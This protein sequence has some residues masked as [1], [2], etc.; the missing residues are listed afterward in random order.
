MRKGLENRVVQRATALAA[1]AGTLVLSACGRSSHYLTSEQ[2]GGLSPAAR[3]D[4]DFGGGNPAIGHELPT[5]A[6][7]GNCLSGTPF[8]P[9]Q[10]AGWMPA[11]V[12]EH[13]GV[14]TVTRK[15]LSDTLPGELHFTNQG[16]D[17]TL[18][19]ADPQTVQ[20]LQ[21]KNCR[22]GEYSTA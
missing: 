5:G 4:Y 8:D 7:Y 3:V 2:I 16:P 13:E 18:V 14:I 6:Y 15:I 11:E 1:L 17:Q 9:G 20:V 10:K 12:T 22:V 21:D 19:P